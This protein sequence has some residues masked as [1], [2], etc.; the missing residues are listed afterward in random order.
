MS[1]STERLIKDLLENPTFTTWVLE[2]NPELDQYWAAWSDGD[3][4]RKT[5]LDKARFT[6][7]SSKK[8][9]AGITDEH[10]AYKVSQSLEIAKRREKSLKNN[11]TGSNYLKSYWLAAAS[12]VLVLA[13]G[14]GV[15]KNYDTKSVFS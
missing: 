15:Y 7:L 11:N 2:E 9:I 14:L 8:E 4:C 10:I 12:V 5:A 1:S 13:I 3:F 6:L